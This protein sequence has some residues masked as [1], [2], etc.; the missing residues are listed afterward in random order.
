[1]VLTPPFKWD[2][3]IPLVGLSQIP[4]ISQYNDLS[5]VTRNGMRRLRKLKLELSQEEAVRSV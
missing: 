3:P 5:F 1:M 4:M 2:I